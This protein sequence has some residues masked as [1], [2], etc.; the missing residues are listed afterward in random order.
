MPIK[1]SIASS[2]S[3]SNTMNA[4]NAQEQMPVRRWYCVERKR[5]VVHV[6]G[7]SALGPG[8]ALPYCRVR[9][10]GTVMG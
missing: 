8:R 5:A 10:S 1:V 2:S 9:L 7:G 6:N 3:R 4:I